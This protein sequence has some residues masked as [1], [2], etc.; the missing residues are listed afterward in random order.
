MSFWPQAA[1]GPLR[2]V[3]GTRVEV[4]DFVDRYQRVTFDICQML[5]RVNY[6]WRPVAVLGIWAVTISIVGLAL[7]PRGRTRDGP[8]ISPCEGVVSPR[9]RCSPG[10]TDVDCLPALVSRFPRKVTCDRR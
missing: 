8:A 10:V 1:K 9:L 7:P 2:N 3:W 4:L 5:W 6:A